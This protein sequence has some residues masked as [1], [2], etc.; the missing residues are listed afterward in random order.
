[1]FLKYGSKD[2]IYLSVCLSIYLST[3]LP[4][5]LLAFGLMLFMKKELCF[6]YFTDENFQVVTGHS[7]ISEVLEWPPILHR[8]IFF[9]HLLCAR[10]VARS[11]I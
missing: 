8:K 6:F 9:E 3:Y 11:S 4:T 10:N 2:F 7:H 1:M 5:Y